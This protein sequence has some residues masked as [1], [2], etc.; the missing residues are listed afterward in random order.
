M[1]MKIIK[2]YIQRYC[3]ILDKMIWDMTHQQMTD[4]ISHM[5]IVRMLP[6]HR[7]AIEMSKN[8]L[9]YTN[10]IPVRKIASDII[11]Q[12]TK[13]IRA[14][15]QALPS[16]SAIANPP[17]ELCQYHKQYEQISQTMFL[18]MRSAETVGNL[19]V[20]FMR[21][22][23]PHHRG[24]VKMSENA[25]NFKVCPELIPMLQSIIILQKAGIQE[26]Q[27]LLRTI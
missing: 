19:N 23:I 21:E 25:L 11:T 24:A 8:I 6:H 1:Q 3:E 17:H 16:C 14:L 13:S 27:C 12:Q 2:N 7:A 26:M 20:D 15:E 4:S 22:M 5:F 10:D 18:Q 9:M